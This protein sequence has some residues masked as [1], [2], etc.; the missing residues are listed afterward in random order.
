MRNIYPKLITT[1][2]V[3]LFVALVLK[4]SDADSRSAGG[5]STSVSAIRT[6]QR[7]N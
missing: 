6:S 1:L 7:A 2:F 5:H 3:I 4:Y